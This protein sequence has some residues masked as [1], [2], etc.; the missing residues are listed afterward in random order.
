M[1]VRDTL[2]PHIRGLP[3]NVFRKSVFYPGTESETETLISVLDGTESE[4]HISDLDGRK[5]RK[6]P[7]MYQAT[8]SFTSVVRF[9]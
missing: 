4:F 5:C 9:Y 2:R 1:A 7:T 8:G 3:T 6:N